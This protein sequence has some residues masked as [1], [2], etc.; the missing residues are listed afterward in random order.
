MTLRSTQ[1]TSWRGVDEASARSGIENSTK[2]HQWDAGGS[3]YGL[4]QHVGGADSAP[5]ATLSR[6]SQRLCGNVRRGAAAG[7]DLKQ[8]WQ[9][10]AHA[11]MC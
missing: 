7:V 4:S 11:H 1:N 8:R 6:A 5:V 10:R 2:Q 3:N 9:Q